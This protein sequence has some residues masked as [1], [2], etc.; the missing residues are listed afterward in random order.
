[1]TPVRTAGVVV[2]AITLGLAFAAATLVYVVPLRFSLGGQVASYFFALVGIVLSF[3]PL[4]VAIYAIVVLRRMD[5]RIG[6]IAE[7]TAA[8]RERVEGRR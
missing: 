6:S 4:A 7:E 2:F 5:E 3:T 1:M 8:I